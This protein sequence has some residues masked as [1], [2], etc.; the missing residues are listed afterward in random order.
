MIVGRG[1][2]A[3]AFAPRYARDAST[4]VFASGVSNSRE[5]RSEEFAREREML[6]W[7]MSTPGGVVVY[8]STCS[9]TDPD[10]VE[11]PYVKHK[12]AMEKMLAGGPRSSLVAR[13]PQVVGNTSNPNTLTNFLCRAIMRG[14]EVPVWR[15]AWRNLIDIDDVAA[16]APRL[17]D[18]H[19]HGQRI[20][21]IAS[22]YGIPM[23]ELV[24]IVER[25]LDRKALVRLEDRGGRSDMDTREAST[26]A[27]SA[28]VTFRPDYVENVIEKYY[29]GRKS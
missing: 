20:V 22:P 21:N 7:V 2:L 15:H 27:A 3:A 4:T 11:T 28:G 16:I 13:L 29:G 24:R 25:V 1:F 5:T 23:P 17:I 8:F 14:E 10:R 26:A 12:L 18:T 6:R 19:A 9:V